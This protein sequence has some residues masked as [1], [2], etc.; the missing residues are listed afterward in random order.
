MNSWTIN[1]GNSG[2]NL[3]GRDLL[4]YMENQVLF[5]SEE[6]TQLISDKEVVVIAISCQQSVPLLKF[7]KESKK[8]SLQKKSMNRGVIK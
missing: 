3:L 4:K 5:Y 7:L 8:Y 2:A 1:L 6:L